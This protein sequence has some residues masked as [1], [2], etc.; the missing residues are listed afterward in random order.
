MSLTYS[1]STVPPTDGGYKYK[2]HKRNEA[3]V[4][5]TIIEENN[6]AAPGTSCAVKH[7]THFLKEQGLP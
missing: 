6:R 2:T 5:K 3:G 1:L 4:S 7:T